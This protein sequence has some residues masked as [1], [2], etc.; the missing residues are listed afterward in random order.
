MRPHR[1]AP[2]SSDQLLMA[3]HILRALEYGGMPMHAAGYLELASW[4]TQELRALDLDSLIALSHE[5][6]EGL[7]LIVDNVLHER[8]SFD[9]P[10]GGIEALVAHCAWRS[11]LRSLTAHD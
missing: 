2:L 7:R 3:S 8:Q 6:P 11:L 4:V 1:P 5:A 10:L 9:A